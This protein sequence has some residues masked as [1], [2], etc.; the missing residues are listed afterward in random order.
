[1]RL[2]EHVFDF[3]AAVNIP[4]GH[5]VI[6][7]HLNALRRKGLWCLSLTGIFHDLKGLLRLYALMQQIGHNAVTGSD[8]V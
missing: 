1:M 4:L 8:N 7:Q 5:I 2:R 3:Q 6:L